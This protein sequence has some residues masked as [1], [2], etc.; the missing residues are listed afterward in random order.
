MFQNNSCCIDGIFF[1]KKRL[2]NRCL[3]IYWFKFS[4]NFMLGILLFLF[5]HPN[6]LSVSFIRWIVLVVVVINLI[7]INK[8]RIISLKINRIF[9][10]GKIIKTNVISELSYE[11]ASRFLFVG[12]YHICSMYF[13]CSRG[14][15]IAFY[16]NGHSDRPVCL[17]K[18]F[19]QGKDIRDLKTIDVLVNVNNYNEYFVLFREELNIDISRKWYFKPINVIDYLLWYG[20]VIFL[21]MFTS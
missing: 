9:N 21:I 1:D 16:F 4:F 6:M 17:M 5:A 7:I 11:R 19:R 15:N 18:P 20:S 2:L 10:S 13:D 8:I 3:E 14:E 12:R